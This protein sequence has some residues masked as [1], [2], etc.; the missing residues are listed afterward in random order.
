MELDDFRL[1]DDVP[2]QVEVP[3][4]LE[5]PRMLCVQGIFDGATHLVVSSFCRK[6]VGRALDGLLGNGQCAVGRRD[7]AARGTP[8]GSSACRTE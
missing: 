7:V 2:P 5:P 8:K 1:D 6:L 4:L 3:L